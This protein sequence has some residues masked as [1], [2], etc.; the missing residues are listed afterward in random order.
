LSIYTQLGLEKPT[1]SMINKAKHDNHWEIMRLSKDIAESV[2][3]RTE[4]TLIVDDINF[5]RELMDSIELFIRP[6][7]TNDGDYLRYGHGVKITAPY[8]HFVEYGIGPS[9]VNIDALKNWVRGKLKINDPDEIDK[10]TTLVYYK[11]LHKGIEPTWFFKRAI[12]SVAKKRRVQIMPK[13]TKRQLKQHMGILPRLRNKLL[14]HAPITP[15][16]PKT[17]LKRIK[18]SEKKF[19]TR[20]KRLGSRWNRLVNKMR[21]DKRKKIANEKR[22][23]RLAEKQKRIEARRIK[24]KLR[25]EKRAE[26][27][28]KAVIRAHERKAKAIERTKR[29]VEKNRLRKQKE[30]AKRSRKSIKKRVTRK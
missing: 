21:R 24:A 17:K 5:T 9:S 28:A 27:H 30:R 2:K 19:R 14:G 11:I 13:T 16:N 15:V 18:K 10:I 6:A 23:A 7:F 25:E 22:I 1:I 29:I 20:P 12:K 3:I 8:A 26:R 4:R